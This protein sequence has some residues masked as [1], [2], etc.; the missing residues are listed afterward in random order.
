MAVGFKSGLSVQS[1]Y[2]VFGKDIR[3]HIRHDKMKAFL[4]IL[5]G[6]VN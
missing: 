5:A 1:C 3:G 6:F 2:N 4:M